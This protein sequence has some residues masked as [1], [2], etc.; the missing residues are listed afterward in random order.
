V[1]KAQTYLRGLDDWAEYDRI[2]VP[3]GH[4]PA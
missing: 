2:D 4:R 1:C 3:V